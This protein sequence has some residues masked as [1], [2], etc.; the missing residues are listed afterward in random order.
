MEALEGRGHS[1]C[2]S[3][4]PNRVVPC[5][6]GRGDSEEGGGE[7]SGVFV[8]TPLCVHCVSDRGD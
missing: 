8:Q 6:V 5:R 7:G 3:K 4:D 1:R 2:R